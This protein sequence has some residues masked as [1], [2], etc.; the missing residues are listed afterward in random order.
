[1]RALAIVHQ[2]DAGPGVFAEALA[3]KGVELDRWL[4]ADA[5]APADPGGYDAVLTFGGAMHTDHEAD[6]P[7]LREE[8]SILADLIERRVPL[9]GMCLGCQ[10]VAEAAGAKPRRASAPEIGWDEVELTPEAARRPAARRAPGALLGVPV[11]QLR[12]AAPARGHRAR[13]QPG[14]PAGLPARAA[15]R[16]ASSSTRR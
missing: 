1:M 2:P 11:A 10:L 8:K 16:G 12:G 5:P 14:L 13:P 6:H 9:L 3:A 15:R 7:W 4:I